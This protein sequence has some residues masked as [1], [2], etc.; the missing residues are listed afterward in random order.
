[1]SA[2]CAGRELDLLNFEGHS[3]SGAMNMGVPPAVTVVISPCAPGMKVESPKSAR[4]AWGGVPLVIKMFCCRCCEGYGIAL[5]A[6]NLLLS[7]PREQSHACVGDINPQR[8][9]RAKYEAE[10][11]LFVTQKGYHT[12]RCLFAGFFRIYTIMFPFTI[13]SEIIEYRPVRGSISTAMSF[14]RLGC[15]TFIQMMHSLQK[16]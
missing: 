7:N 1:M 13:I 11:A 5:V 4:Q 14:K 10:S 2:G 15:E 3:S 9:P 16:R 12:R 8:L 6:V